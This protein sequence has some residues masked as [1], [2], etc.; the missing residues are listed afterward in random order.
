MCGKLKSQTINGPDSIPIKPTITW[1]GIPPGR[2]DVAT[3]KAVKQIILPKGFILKKA[4]VNFI[5]PIKGD[6]KEHYDLFSTDL[7]PIK[8]AMNKCKPG[9]VIYIE[10]IFVADANGKLLFLRDAGFALF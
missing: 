4:I 6:N 9:T 10:K 8:E 2:M 1:G 7:S 5:Y 3:F